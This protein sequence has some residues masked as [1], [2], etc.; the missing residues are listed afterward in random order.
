MGTPKHVDMDVEKFLAGNFKMAD[1]IYLG[2]SV[3]QIT[4]HNYF[5]TMIA[6]DNCFFFRHHHIVIFD[7]LELIFKKIFAYAQFRVRFHSKN[8]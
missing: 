6:T 4:S 7:P 2:H 3:S 1:F 5:H 8:C